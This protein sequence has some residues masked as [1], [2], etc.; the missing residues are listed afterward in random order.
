M[1]PGN[2]DTGILT[3][4]S[5]ST[6]LTKWLIPRLPD[7]RKTAPNVTLSFSQHLGAFEN[8]PTGGVAVAILYGHGGWSGVVS[9]YI[10]GKELVLIASPGL[11]NAEGLIT[12]AKVSKST[13]L[14]H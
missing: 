1:Q 13:L 14:N 5:A 2:G 11:V 4:A 10:A 12:A 9:D 6:F 8:M 7:F 3:L